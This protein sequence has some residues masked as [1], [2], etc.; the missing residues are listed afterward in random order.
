MP[1]QMDNGLGVTMRDSCFN[2]LSKVVIKVS[3]VKFD[4][5]ANFAIDIQS[6][7]HCI[8]YDGHLHHQIR[9]AQ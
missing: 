6:C 5:L 9:L 1:D 4:N 8:D 2:P 3:P 7:F